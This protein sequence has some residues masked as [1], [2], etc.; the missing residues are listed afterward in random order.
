MSNNRLVV[1]A[2]YDRKGEADLAK[3]RLQAMGIPCMVS[4]AAQSGL[5]MIYD[6]SNG[7]Q[8]KVPADQ[9][10]DARAALDIDDL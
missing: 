8:V 9:A 10:E 5:S 3:A 1:I 4:N 2:R 7:V 6:S